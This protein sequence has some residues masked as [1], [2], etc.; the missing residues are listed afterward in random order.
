MRRPRLARLA[1]LASLVCLGALA[2]GPA[3]AAAAPAVTLEVKKAD[4]DLGK[5]TQL[6]GRLTG[7]EPEGLP[8]AIVAKEFP[9][10]R[11]VVVDEIVLGPDGRFRSQVK[12]TLNTIYRAVVGTP[13]TEIRSP[14]RRVYISLPNR[15][16]RTRTAGDV[17]ISSF[18]VQFPADYPLPLGG[19]KITWYFRKT[20]DPVFRAVKTSRSKERFGRLVGETRIPLPRGNYSYF[21]TWCFAL[22]KR[23]ADIGIGRNDGGGCSNTLS[24]R[25]AAPSF[26]AR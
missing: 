20:T 7:T 19:R 8:L 22:G 10:K 26:R 3:T 2:L 17:A 14:N 25:V 9:Y 4:I 6:S 23:G 21:I 18:F 24:A 5:G 11:A 13:T 15:E 16:T 12:P 1:V